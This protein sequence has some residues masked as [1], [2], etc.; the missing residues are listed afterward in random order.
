[1]FL[2]SLIFEVYDSLESVE[3][4][5]E[6]LKWG[7]PSYLS[8]HGSTIRIDWKKAKP[9]QYAMYFNCK[10]ALVPTFKEVYGSTFNYEGSRAIIFD[11]SQD[12]PVKELKHCI[13]LALTYHLVKHLPLLVHKVRGQ[14][15]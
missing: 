14:F 12:V 5:E 2:R 15:Y 7:E 13:Q 11:S 8:E 6:T 9:T 4:M 3:H 10:S 1:M